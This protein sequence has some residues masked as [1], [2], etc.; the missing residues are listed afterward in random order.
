MRATATWQRQVREEPAQTRESGAP[1]GD[2][3]AQSADAPA[4]TPADRRRTAPATLA[5]AVPDAP[6]DETFSG[7]TFNRETVVRTAGAEG[8][9]ASRVDAYLAAA[10]ED[11]DEDET[12]IRPAVEPRR[13]GLAGAPGLRPSPRRRPGPGWASA[14]PARAPAGPAPAGPPT[15]ARPGRPAAAR[16]PRAGRS[17]PADVETGRRGHRRA[18]PP[19]PSHPAIR[20]PARAE[21][22]PAEELSLDDVSEVSDF[23]TELPAV[24]PP[25][26]PR[27]P[28][29]HPPIPRPGT[30]AAPPPI[31][32]PPP[33]PP[34][35]HSASM[36]AIPHGRPVVT[37]PPLGP[38]APSAACRARWCPI[39]SIPLDLDDAEIIDS[40]IDL[41]PTDDGMAPA[42]LEATVAP[43]V[44][45]ESHLEV[46]TALDRAMAETGEAAL[47]KR[48]ADLVARPRQRDRPGD[49]R[50]LRR[51]SSASCTSAGSPTR[52][53]RSRRSAGPCRPIRRCAPTCGRSAACS[54]AAACG[55][56]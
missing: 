20:I 39:P 15:R 49:H 54:T 10:D 26:P 53:A 14:P 32:R 2:D 35:G 46:P 12:G 16:M 36:P 6:A 37:V 44:P 5:A 43:E 41:S 29:P 56:T 21:S 25:P 13:W 47:E 22:E 27:P 7:D 4:R 31:P 19:R 24:A 48:A 28:P 45:L 50:R 34:S 51:T 42:S 55:P 8:S 52:P 33:R 30:I 1:P 18:A 38:P 40:G 3:H 17:E 11:D 23:S 9:L